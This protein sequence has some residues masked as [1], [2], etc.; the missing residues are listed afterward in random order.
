MNLKYRKSIQHVFTLEMLTEDLQCESMLPLSNSKR[1]GCLQ[2]QI[3]ELNDQTTL[4]SH[5]D[6]H[7]NRILI[8]LS[9][10]ARC[11]EW[12]NIV[13]MVMATHS[14]LTLLLW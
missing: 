6:H 5:S 11:S 4:E 9:F 7:S 8:H 1:S 13:A 3:N 2:F 12:A 14:G 10:N